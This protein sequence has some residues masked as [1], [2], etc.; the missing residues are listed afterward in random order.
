MLPNNFFHPYHIVPAIK[1]INRI[2][3]T[4]QQ[5]DNQDGDEN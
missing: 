2:Y 3:E 1:F 5:F 4:P